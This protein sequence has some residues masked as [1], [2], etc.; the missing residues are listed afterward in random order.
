MRM[1]TRKV[2]LVAVLT[3]VASVV[4]P[5]SAAA[6]AGIS[7]Q[8]SWHAPTQGSH[9]S[10]DGTRAGPITCGTPLGTGRYR[11]R[12]R[13][14]LTPPTASEAASPRLSF[15]TGTVHG[16]F[17]VSGTFSSQPYHYHGTFHTSGGTGQFKHVAGTLQVSCTIR[18]TDE[19]CRASGRLAGI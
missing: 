17:R 10:V 16:S 5:A 15:Q 12:Y 19:T 6:P 1:P 7:V 2:V 8:C 4:G 14:R 11:A 3:A 13:D 18:T 9:Y